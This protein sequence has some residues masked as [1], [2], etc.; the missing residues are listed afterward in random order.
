M[1]NH[2]HYA[3][4]CSDQRCFYK[5]RMQIVPD[6]REQNGVSVRL[7]EL[8]A[9]SLQRFRIDTATLDPVTSY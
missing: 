8:M 2:L 3:G 7:G 1:P 4:W 5:I 9:V 6:L